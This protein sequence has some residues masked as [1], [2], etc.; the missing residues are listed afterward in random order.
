MK[1]VYRNVNTFINACATVLNCHI[2]P[3]DFFCVIKSYVNCERRTI[4][5]NRSVNYIWAALD[6]TSN[7]LRCLLV[8]WYYF[9]NAAH[10]T[11]FLG[12]G[13]IIFSSLIKL[14]IEK[15][16]CLLKKNM[17]IEKNV[18]LCE[19]FHQRPPQIKSFFC[20]IVNQKN[21]LAIC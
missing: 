14:F 20:L 21:S 11:V 9:A 19:W 10:H 18:N 1:R 16:I 17:F 6:R 12:A 8:K 5:W 15:K 13:C 7:T 2:V 4:R 3:F